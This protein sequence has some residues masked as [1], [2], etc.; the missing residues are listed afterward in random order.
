MT[1]FREVGSGGHC[2]SPDTLDVEFGLGQTARV[3][4]IEIRWPSG[5]VSVLNNVPVDQKIIVTEGQ[6]GYKV[7]WRGINFPVEPRGKLATTLGHVKGT[8][9]YQ[10]Y[11]NPFNPE[12]W[13]PFQLAED[14]DVSI[15]IYSVNGKLVK[16]LRKKQAST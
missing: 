12:T 16:T 2:F 11:P 14:T 3:D 5:E 4:T 10:N 7:A 6:A 8:V 15:N 9:L 13:I 1:Q